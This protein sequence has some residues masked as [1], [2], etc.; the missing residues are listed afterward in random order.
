MFGH[1]NHVWRWSA[2]KGLFDEVNC[3]SKGCTNCYIATA[4]GWENKSNHLTICCEIYKTDLLTTSQLKAFENIGLT[5]MSPSQNIFTVESTIISLF[6]ISISLQIM[7]SRRSIQNRLYT[8]LT[9]ST[10]EPLQGPVSSTHQRSCIKI[11]HCAITH[12]SHTH[13]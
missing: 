8:H 3:K 13:P 6:P 2:L 1:V 10:Y 9:M 11:S 5:L 7:F 4:D 12:T